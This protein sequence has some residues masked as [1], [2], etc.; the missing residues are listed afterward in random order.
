V[1]I[2]NNFDEFASASGISEEGGDAND[3]MSR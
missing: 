3:A 1:K 2:V